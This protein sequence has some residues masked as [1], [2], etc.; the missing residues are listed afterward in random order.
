MKLSSGKVKKVC[1]LRNLTLGEAIDG[2]GVSRTA[3]YSLLRKGSV[4]PRSVLALADFLRVKPGE[5]LERTSRPERRARLLLGIL[6]RILVRHPTA[7]RENVWHTLLLLD[8]SPVDRL[9]RGLLR[10][11]ALDLHS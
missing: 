6:E 7:N 4:L 9:E 2:A 10:G 5:L 11:T 3:Y 8:E 1:R